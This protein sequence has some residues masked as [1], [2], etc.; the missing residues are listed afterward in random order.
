M[1][2]LGDVLGRAVLETDAAGGL[3]LVWT[4][5]TAADMR[6]HGVTMDQLEGVIDI[7]RTSR[8]AEVAVVCKQD[9]DGSMKVSTR[10]KG[11]LDVGAV[12]VALGGGGHRFAAGFT[13]TADVAATM[14][15]LR[16]QLAAAPHLP[17]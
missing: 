10:S 17:E 6:Q 7:L 12:C 2:L 15:A 11:Q 14:A 16:A 13:S 1:R 3:G 9:T 4:C 5:S 8:E